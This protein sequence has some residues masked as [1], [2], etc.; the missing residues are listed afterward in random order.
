MIDSCALRLS[1]VL[2]HAER[3]R[4]S[5]TVENMRRNLSA[6]RVQWHSRCVACGNRNGQGLRLEFSVRE[7]GYVEASF[8]CDA[9]FEGFPGFLHG[10]IIATLLDAAMT[11]CLFAHGF[12]G[13]TGELKVRYYHPVSIGKVARAY[14]WLERSVHRL[15]G[16]RSELEQDGVIKAAASSRFLETDPAFG[17][18]DSGGAPAAGAGPQK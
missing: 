10:G 8:G 3:C 17:R 9:A 14:A 4:G 5:L 15:H 1:P 2:Q 6:A 7:A 18:D 13:L 11:N 12:I 16:I